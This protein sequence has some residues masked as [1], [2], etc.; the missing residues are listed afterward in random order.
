MSALSQGMVSGG[1]FFFAINSGFRGSCWF[2]R[3][4]IL[5]PS[6]IPPDTP[7]TANSSGFQTLLVG[8]GFGF[9]LRKARMISNLASALW[10][11]V[12]VSAVGEESWIWPPT[13]HPT[14][15][16]CFTM[17][18]WPKNLHHSVWSNGSDDKNVN[19]L[20]LQ[21]VIM[22]SQLLSFTSNSTS[23]CNLCCL[24][25]SL[26]GNPW[27]LLTLIRDKKSFTASA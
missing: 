16:Y 20:W 24:L 26:P 21:Y 25:C 7:V 15:F 19:L 4:K 17:I 14:H 8:K 18:H 1:F 13:T 11:N 10:C 2:L 22:C 9:V 23:F 3:D 27:D 12:A 6:L 5:H